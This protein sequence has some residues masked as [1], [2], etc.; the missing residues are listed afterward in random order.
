MA[1]TLMTETSNLPFLERG[2]NGYVQIDY[3]EL[4]ELQL[5]QKEEKEM[6]AV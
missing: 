3:D 2:I 4:L 1:N 6:T 5:R